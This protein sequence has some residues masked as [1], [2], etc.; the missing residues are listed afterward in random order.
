MIWYPPNGLKPKAVKPG[1]NVGTGML[2]TTAWL[3][4][5]FSPVTQVNLP[6]VIGVAASCNSRPWFV[7]SPPLIHCWS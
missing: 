4:A 2:F 1:V 6:I 5:K 7:I 3:R